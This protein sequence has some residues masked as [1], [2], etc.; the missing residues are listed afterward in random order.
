MDK[1]GNIYITAR[2]NG[3]ICKVDTAGNI[4]PVA[5]GGS[6][7]GDGGPA[8]LA[9]IGAPNFACVDDHGNLYITQE[10]NVIRRVDGITGIITTIAGNGTG[11][12]S[13]DGGLATAATIYDPYG[14][15]VDGTGSIFFAD[16]YNN[17]AVRKN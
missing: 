2:D 16:A 15:I 4:Y 10:E 11:G 6:T 3:K 17:H 12:F 14:I 5:G 13:G 7:P 8:T 9:S 1:L